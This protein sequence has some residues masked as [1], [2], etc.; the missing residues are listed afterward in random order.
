MC[1]DSVGPDI[2]RRQK[3][4]LA[5]TA[6]A[7][8][9]ANYPEWSTPEKSSEWVRKMRREADVHTDEKL[10]GSSRVGSSQP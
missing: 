9:D 10:R 6:G 1:N 3:E 2:H 5:A 8:A 4:A 7:L